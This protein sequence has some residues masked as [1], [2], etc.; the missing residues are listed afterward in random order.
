VGV[1][2]AG[3]GYPAYRNAYRPAAYQQ[4][5]AFNSFRAAPS[6]QGGAPA[7]RGGMH[8]GRR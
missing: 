1:G 6:F 5:A 8:M 3:G 4:P 7:F 2:V